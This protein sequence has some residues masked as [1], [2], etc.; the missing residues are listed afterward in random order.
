MS[1]LASPFASI[2]ATAAKTQPSEEVKRR[3]TRLHAE[4]RTKVL[5]L[6]CSSSMGGRVNGGRKIDILRGAIAALTLDEWRIYA[7]N[8]RTDLILPTQIPEPSGGTNLGEALRVI[9]AE[10]TVETLVVSDGV[11]DSEDD[12]LSAAALV[13]GVI[14]TLFVG[15]DFD[16]SAKNFLRRLSRAGCG[17]CYSQDLNAGPQILAQAIKF[18]G[19]GK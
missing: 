1:N 18:L 6:D 10:D 19:P 4:G 7:F 11:P 14:S 2:I 9:S 15:D 8:S 3:V 12:A 13:Q 16:S 5:L 17:K